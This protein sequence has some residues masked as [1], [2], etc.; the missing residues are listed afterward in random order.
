M[1]SGPNV[2]LSRMKAG[3]GRECDYTRLDRKAISAYVEALHTHP[4]FQGEL[5][6]SVYEEK[7]SALREKAEQDALKEAF[8]EV[9]ARA[10]SR[11]SSA[12]LP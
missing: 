8:G 12:Q 3:K 2:E 5:R 4:Q 7:P 6:S 1:A 11:R 9:V 10:L